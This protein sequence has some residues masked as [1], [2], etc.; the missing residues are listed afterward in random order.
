MLWAIFEILLGL[1]LFIFIIWWTVPK[2]K[3]K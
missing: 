3:N 1:G 2:N